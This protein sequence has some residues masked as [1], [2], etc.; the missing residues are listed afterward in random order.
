MGNGN[1][2]MVAALLAV[3]VAAIVGA[4][5]FMEPAETQQVSYSF[6]S[7]DESVAMTYDDLKT[8]CV[9]GKNVKLGAD[10]T[11]GG[12]LTVPENC[13]LTIPH[14][15]KLTQ[16]DSTTLTIAVGGEILNKG[17]FRSEGTANLD[18]N[19]V[20]DVV[21]G[22]K[23]SVNWEVTDHWPSIGMIVGDLTAE[24]SG[25]NSFRVLHQSTGV[26]LYNSGEDYVVEIDCKATGS[27]R[28]TYEYTNYFT[29]NSDRYKVGY[30]M[31]DNDNIINHH[32][33]VVSAG[34][35]T[36]GMANQPVKVDN[37]YVEWGN[38]VYVSV[39]NLQEDSKLTSFA[40]KSGDDVIKVDPNN[41]GIE[42]LCAGNAVVTVT[43]SATDNYLA[44]TADVPVITYRAMLPMY[45]AKW[46]YDGQ[47]FIYDGKVK[48]VT[49][50]GL[51]DNVTVK[52]YENNSASEIGNY[53]ARVKSWN[54][55]DFH[56]DNPLFF[57]RCEWS[58][59]EGTPDSISEVAAVRGSETPTDSETSTFLIALAAIIIAFAAVLV[60]TARAKH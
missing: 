40:V 43:F 51:P 13:Q 7:N 16:P 25:T 6:G 53:T 9:S 18:G 33:Y 24:Y 12:D 32:F 37:V 8:M 23:I 57:D 49:V 19:L 30:I 56:Y 15:Y 55:D 44:G 38:S 42:W 4:V 17:Q 5:V 47:P 1:T 14:G 29:A 3:T 35:L 60:I 10:I 54:Y 46:D 22:G 2:M 36:V 20:N 52:E 39:S 34:T 41:G 48:T 26:D 11:L 58:I 28:G 45:D 21:S 27:S 31:Y 59:Q 50:I